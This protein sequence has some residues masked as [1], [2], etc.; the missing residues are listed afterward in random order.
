MTRPLLHALR[1]RAIL[2]CSLVLTT[3]PLSAQFTTDNTVGT[4]SSELTDFRR[5]IRTFDVEGDGDQDV[6]LCRRGQ[7]HGELSWFENTGLGT[8]A[9]PIVLHSAT[10]AF[11]EAAL[12]FDLADQDTDGDLD[13]VYVTNYTSDIVVRTFDAGA[14]GPAEVWGQTGG[15]NG[16]FVRWM[17][18][19]PWNDQVADVVFHYEINHPNGALNTGGAFGT[20]FI[21]GSGQVGL[22]PDGMEV[23]D[24][25]GNFGDIIVHAASRLYRHTQVSDGNGGYEWTSTELIYNTGPWQVLDVDGDGDDDIGLAHEDSTAWLRSPGLYTDPE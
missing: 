12:D 14:F 4:W 17:Q 24:L 22:G 19:D 18:L 23:G 25:T 10:G 5:V 6:F 8:F 15:S 20:P 3:L 13:I 9:A 1:S 21:I 16:L 11:P 7:E 2:Y